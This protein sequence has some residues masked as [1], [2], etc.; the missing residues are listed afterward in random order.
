MP[1]LLAGAVISHLV[2]SY[3]LMGDLFL[4]LRLVG[5]AVDSRSFLLAPFVAFIMLFRAATSRSNSFRWIVWLTYLVTF[6]LVSLLQILLERRRMQ[7]ARWISQGRCGNCGYDIRATPEC[8]PECGT[9][10]EKLRN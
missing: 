9:T 4:P 3:A 6:T 10:P 5:L 7:P 2:A 1:K 8:C